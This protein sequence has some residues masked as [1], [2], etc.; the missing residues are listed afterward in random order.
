MRHVDVE[1]ADLPVLLGRE[2][3]RGIELGVASGDYSAKLWK[4]GVFS[5]LWGVD[6]YADHHDTREYA[7]ALNLVGLDAN[8]R[9]LRMFFDEAINLFPDQFFD[10][11]YIDGYAHTGENAGKTLYDWYAKVKPGGMIAGHDYSPDWPLVVQAVDRFVSDAGEELLV[12]KLTEKPGPQ[13]DFPSW[14]AF[15]N[16]PETPAYPDELKVL[17]KAYKERKRGKKRLKPV[18]DD[19]GIK[20]SRSLLRRVWDKPGKVK[21]SLAEE[22]TQPLA[23]LQSTRCGKR[24]LI[25]GSAPSISEVDL[26]LAEGVEVFFLNRAVELAND[27]PEGG[28]RL[29]V[30]DPLAASELHGDLDLLKVDQAFLAADVEDIGCSSTFWFEYFRKPMCYEGYA[31]DELGKPLFHCHTVAAFAIQIAVCMGYEDVFLAGVDLTFDESSTHF[32]S[33]SPREKLWQ[34]SLSVPKASRMRAGIAYLAHWADLRG[35]RVVNLSPR[36]SLPLVQN[37]DFVTAFPAN[38]NAQ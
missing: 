11:V 4:S 20:A 25:L 6:A 32:Y 9:L 30:G 15:R 16:S 5:E 27:F 23:K 17:N 2:G 36:R 35:S 28:R 10:F 37:M 3:L 34:S 12:S 24:C 13:D 18:S 31:Q 7:S 21:T 26:S 33:S 29:V 22:M 19:A 1:R 14:A 38:S 8:Y